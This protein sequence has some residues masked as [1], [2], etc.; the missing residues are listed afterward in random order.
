ME[1]ILRKGDWYRSYEPIPI[2]LKIASGP[3]LTSRPW[4]ALL[5]AG[6]AF[7]VTRD[8]NYWDSTVQC[9]PARPEAL[10]KLLIPESD[11]AQL[12]QWFYEFWVPVAVIR[13]KCQPAGL[14]SEVPE[15]QEP[16]H[17]QPTDQRLLIWPEDD[18]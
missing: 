4:H 17:R 12:S 1:P 5:P 10:E 13:E 6:W 7:H 9:E 15:E 3:P 8:C 14:S 11:R 2:T 18:N 16:N